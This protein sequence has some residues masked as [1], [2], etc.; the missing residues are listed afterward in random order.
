MK[1]TKN[2]IQAIVKELRG[3]I[4]GLFAGD[5]PDV[6]LFGSYAKGTVEEGSDID[7]MLLVDAPRSKIAEKNWQ[8]GDMAADLLLEY[9]IVV[10][11]IVENRE[12]FYEN[13]AVMPFFRTIQNEGTRFD[14]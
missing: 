14:G 12:F 2:E 6:F 8:V 9:G 4:S 11:P 7:V 5:D 1:Q 13:A 3:G 10:S